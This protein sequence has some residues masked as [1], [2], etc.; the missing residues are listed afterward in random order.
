MSYLYEK[1]MWEYYTNLN[2]II[3][4]SLQ[5]PK[6]VVLKSGKCLADE[7]VAKLIKLATNG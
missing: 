5:K 6:P 2:R 1:A 3:N 4:K 7:E